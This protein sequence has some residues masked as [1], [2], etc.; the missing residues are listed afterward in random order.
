MSSYNVKFMF[1]DASTIEENFESGVTILDAKQKLI[2]NW[3]SGK[4][5][6][7][8]PD[9]LKLI[10]GGKVLDNL[11]SFE[12]IRIPSRNQVIM[13][14][15]PRPPQPPSTEKLYTL[16]PPNPLDQSRCCTIL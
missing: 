6:V 11:K 4:E 2:A 15:Q 13:H 8:G 16:P 5:P 7:T 1:A 9:D 10:Y 3:P 14:C 12:E